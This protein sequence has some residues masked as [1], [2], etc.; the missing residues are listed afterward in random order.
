MGNTSNLISSET[1]IS[2]EIP[3]SE[4]ENPNFHFEHLLRKTSRDQAKEMSND[5]LLLAESRSIR[6]NGRFVTFE[7]GDSGENEGTRDGT[8]EGGRVC[9]NGTMEEKREGAL[10]ADRLSPAV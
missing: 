8:E 2:A 6:E 3:R 4:H 5:S 7:A 10:V 9:K 1:R